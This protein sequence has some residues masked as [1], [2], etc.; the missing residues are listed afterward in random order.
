MRAPILTGYGQTRP[1]NQ[2]LGYL[3]ANAGPEAFGE[4][5]ARGAGALGESLVALGISYQERD[6]K[7]QR[8][9]ALMGESEFRENVTE[10]LANLKRTAPMNA[11]FPKMTEE[12][13]STYERQY[14]ATLPPH[15]AP[16]FQ[17]RARETK[18][19]IMAD[20]LDF[21]FSQQDAFAKEGIETEYE[22]A[23]NAVHQTPDEYEKWL[24]HMAELVTSS[25]LPPEQKMVLAG[26]IRAGLLAVKYGA[27]IERAVRTDT[28]VP[29]DIVD[30]IIQVE[31]GGDPNA[32]PS[33]ST[34][35]GL[36]Q[37]TQGTWMEFIREAHP[38]LLSQ[39]GDVQ[40]LRTDRGLGREAV[41]WYIRKNTLR[42]QREGLPV[43]GAN[44]YLAHF[45]GPGGASALLKAFPDQ[46]VSEVLGVDQIRANASVLQGKTVA[47]VIDWAQ[48]KMG[49][50]AVDSVNADPLYGEVPLE[51]RIAAERSAEATV[52]K[53]IAEAAA[54]AK[55]AANAARNTLY[56]DL[57]FG[58]AS[59]T[60]IQ[61]AEGAGLLDDYADRNRAY[62]ILARKQAAF[63]D[64]QEVQ[65]YIDNGGLGWNTAFAEKYNK[66][67]DRDMRAAVAAGNQDLINSR[68]LP[69]IQTLHD[70]PT[71]LVGQ[72]EAMSRNTNPQAA[73]FALDTLAQIRRNDPKAF[74]DRVGEA[75]AGDV[76]FWE[77]RKDLLP[78][79]QVLQRINGGQLPEERQH[80][81]G[82]EEEARKILTD[83]TNNTPNSEQLLANLLA[84][85]DVTTGFGP[86][87]PQI[88]SIPWA[89]RGVS[90]DFQTLFID[91][92][93]KYGEQQAAYDYAEKQLGRIYGTTS[94]G[95]TDVFMK[96][97]PEKA[98]YRTSLGT[99]AWIDRQVRAEMG[100]DEATKFQLITDAQTIQEFARWQG[101]A[102]GLPP[103]YLVAVQRDGVWEIEQ[104][105]RGMPIRKYFVQGIN[106]VEEE[107]RNFERENTRAKIE[108]ELA[109]LRGRRRAAQRI[110]EPIPEGI[111]ARIQE[112]EQQLSGIKEEPFDPT[113]FS[114]P[115]VDQFQPIG[116]IERT[117]RAREGLNAD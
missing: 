67:F 102:T 74:N 95:G 2:G 26:N 6:K 83:K 54:A 13:Y 81:K 68:V 56:N 79:E 114:L 109:E 23:R 38:E 52:A 84:A 106:E 1:S 77:A 28:A 18:R 8:F 11:N 90:A 96:L 16:E 7:S 62:D 113:D 88:P 53:D 25:T 30:R 55:D 3:Q 40:K 49:G 116:A 24:T 19:G 35:L 76:E 107:A 108:S 37:F 100:Y 58:D 9:G 89:A 63:A 70:I 69:A 80:R 61:A 15:L 4:D 66:W 5:I 91:G 20:A 78:Q 10:A 115:N 71:D 72:L 97:P 64:A 17:Y 34:A 75:L 33:T 93:V 31:S 87:N 86:S 101:D 105:A 60:Q 14:I 110:F 104:D 50:V 82:L 117:E 29:D 103:S 85:N 27:D 41:Q 45:L 92:Y 32:S 65:G 12:L 42:L 112:L 21:Q 57:E 39:G 43:T 59:Y 51:T 46:P 94:I 99:H 47:E 111:D 73:S 98:G 44:I 48:K 36:G 22:R